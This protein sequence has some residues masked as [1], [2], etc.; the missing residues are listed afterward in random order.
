MPE[1]SL[2]EVIRNAMDHR[3]DR[4]HVAKICRVKSYDPTTQSADIVPVVRR[5]V[6]DENND[7]IDSEEICVL[8]NVPI[9]QLRAGGFFVHLP[10]EAGDHVLAI[11]SEDSFQ[12]WRETGSVSDPGDQRRHSLA[13]A[14]A[15][16][17][18]ASMLDPLSPAPLD[19]A[20]RVA[21]LVIG[22]DGDPAQIQWG[23]TGI[24]LGSLA[25]SPVALAVP[26]LAYVAA[27]AA[28]ATAGG[29]SDTAVGAAL[30][31]IQAALAAIVA[32]PANAAAAPAV[33][34]SGTAVTA[35][36]TATSAAATAATAAGLAATT[37]A[38]AVP[39]TIVQA[40]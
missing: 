16:P 2:D 17:G 8:P 14:V 24:K 20:A 32:I 18:I 6:R 23:P 4:V 3:L 11:F 22:K 38:T 9:L 1:R 7:V 13:N 12:Y 33:T 40:Q 25:I 36:T 21:G 28:A 35:A 10:V 5:S 34:A 15:I 39:A 27:A 29:A 37:A 19:L 26:L 31:A 30:T